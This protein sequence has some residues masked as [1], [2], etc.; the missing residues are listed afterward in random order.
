MW[1]IGDQPTGIVAGTPA[2]G[3]EIET[4]SVK[5]M[6]LAATEFNVWGNWTADKAAKLV[7]NYELSNGRTGST[8]VAPS[9]VTGTYDLSKGGIYNITINFLGE[10]LDASLKVTS[11]TLQTGFFVT[12]P[13]SPLMLTSVVPQ[14]DGTVKTET[15]LLRDDEWTGSIGFGVVG[16]Y[17]VQVKPDG[18][19]TYENFTVTVS[20]MVYFQNFDGIKDGLTEAEVLEAT[21]VTFPKHITAN[22]WEVGVTGGRLTTKVT[23]ANVSSAGNGKVSNPVGIIIVSADYLKELAN[24]DYTIQFDVE[25]LDVVGATTIFCPKY[26]DDNPHDD[27]KYTVNALGLELTRARAGLSLFR[28]WNE[29]GPHAAIG[30]VPNYAS[31]KAWA[32]GIKYNDGGQNLDFTTATWTNSTPGSFQILYG[33]G[34]EPKTEDPTRWANNVITVKIVVKQ[35]NNADDTDFDMEIYVKAADADDSTFIKLYALNRSGKNDGVGKQFMNQENNLLEDCF[36]ILS[37][38][39]QSNW[40]LDNIA[41]WT[42]TGAMPEITDASGYAALVEAANASDAG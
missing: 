24:F 6:S 20:N 41:I 34:F 5:T 42:G 10:T 40:A 12:A 21:G 9:M 29:T 7:L 22:D 25:M 11:Y 32:A 14:E 3:G 8:V 15:R 37:V 18:F 16:S 33:L 13:E 23:N 36:A 26:S 31:N 30:S 4:V 39:D 19:D 1:W 27:T 38:V 28:S 17:P 35:K 2:E